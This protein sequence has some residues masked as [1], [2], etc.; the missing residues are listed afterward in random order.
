VRTV[1]SVGRHCEGSSPA[2]GRARGL[3]LQGIEAGGQ[4][5]ELRLTCGACVVDFAPGC[6]DG[7]A[8]AGRGLCD[9]PVEYGHSSISTPSGTLVLPPK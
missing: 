7:A 2:Q 4:G 5:L 6:G 9:G 8:R 3:E 1:A